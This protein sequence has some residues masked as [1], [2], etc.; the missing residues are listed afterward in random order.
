MADEKPIDEEKKKK[1]KE[2]LDFLEKKKEE[3]LKKIARDS[4]KAKQIAKEHRK[5]NKFRRG[6]V[7]GRRGT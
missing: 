2:E 7:R 5:Q 4:S 1:I 6:N 3:H